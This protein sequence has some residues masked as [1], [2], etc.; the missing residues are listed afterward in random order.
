MNESCFVSCNNE[1]GHKGRKGHVKRTIALVIL[2]TLGS[3]AIGRA[4]PEGY[5]N[6]VVLNICQ[7]ERTGPKVVVNYTLPQSVKTE[8]C[9]LTIRLNDRTYTVAY[10]PLVSPILPNRDPDPCFEWN[11]G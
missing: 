1:I 9:R 8:T 10:T 4:Q 11:K 2:L 6:A 3:A 5:Q 7:E